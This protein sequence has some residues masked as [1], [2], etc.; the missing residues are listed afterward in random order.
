MKI[1][2]LEWVSVFKKKCLFF[3]REFNN[4]LNKKR[5]RLYAYLLP[6]KHT[7]YNIWVSVLRALSIKQ[8]FLLPYQRSWAIKRLR[9]LCFHSTC[10]AIKSE[11][12]LM[13]SFSWVI[14]FV[15]VTAL[16]H[17]RIAQLSILQGKYWMYKL[18]WKVDHLA[19]HQNKTKRT[20]PTTILVSS[21]T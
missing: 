1:N 3:V 14:Y 2:K 4:I 7:D 16:Q 18:K 6:N 15:G 21:T 11:P 10:T 17:D 8:A 9:L 20:N 13:N 12:K 19:E 5:I